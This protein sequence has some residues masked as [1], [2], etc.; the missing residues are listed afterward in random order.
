MVPADSPL[1][2]GGRRISLAVV[3]DNEF[4]GENAL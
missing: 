4:K 1:A 3:G 2:D